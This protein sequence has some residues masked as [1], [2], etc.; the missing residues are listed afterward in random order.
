MSSFPDDTMSRTRGVPRALRR[1]LLPAAVLLVAMAT[2]APASAAI[3]SRGAA[4]VSTY[5]SDSATTIAVS[6]PAGAQPG[7]VLVASIGFGRSSAKSQPALTAP[8]GWTLVLRTNQGSVGALAVYRHVYAAGETSY[9]WTANAA[10]GGAAFVSAF[11]GV[12][13][14]NPVDTSAGRTMGKA[15]SVA[16]PSITASAAGEMLVASYY[17]YR[18]SGGGTTWTPPP[19]MSELGDASNGSSRSGSVDAALQSSAGSTG[20][21]TAKASAQQDYAIASLLALRPAPPPSTPPVID[22]VQAGAVST[23]TATVSWITDQPADSQVD[24]GQ[25]SSYGATKTNGTA[26]AIHSQNLTGL[27][28]NAVYHYRVSSRNASGQV[29]VSPDYTFQTSA[30]GAVPLI[31]DTDIFSDADDVGALASA[32]GLQVRGEAQVVAIGVNTRLSRPAVATSSWKC[33]S[34]ITAFYNSFAVPIGTA[35]PNNGTAVNSPDFVGP[36]S[37]LAPASTPTPESAVTVYRRAL[38][39]AP[40]GSVVMASVGYFGNLSALLDSPAD[41]ISLLTG[42]QL[43]AQKVNSLVAMAG[44]YP[45]NSGENNI[46][47]DPASAQDVAANW[48]TKIIWSGYEVGD[49]V[50]TGQTISSVHPTNSPVRVAYEAFAGAGNWIYSYDLTAIYHAIRPADS[51]LSEVGPG[52]NQISNTGANSFVSGSGNQYYLAL[53][54]ATS[55]DSSIEALLDTLP[56]SSAPPPDT[57][58]PAITGVSA[59]SV[60]SGE[61]TVGW[62]TDE[63]ATTQV[64]Y[65]TTTA[66]GS[67]TTP[68]TSLGTSHSQ[69]LSGLTPGTLY[70]YRVKSTDA[71]GNAAVSGDFT[72]TTTAAQASGLN[73]NFDSNT[74]DPGV[75]SLIQGGSTV[76]AAN[77]ELEITHPA[78]SW[79]KSGVV[80]AVTE[81]ATG[82]SVQVQLKRAANNGLGGSTYGETTIYLML[83][84]THYASFFVASGKLTA[85][86]NTGG[87]ESNQTPSWPTYNATNMQ[88]LRFRESAGRLYWEY[89]SGT[90]TPGPW[91]TLVSTGTPFAL[92][93]VR[94][95][96]VAG[97]NVNV[98]DTAKFDNVATY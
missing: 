75:W 68:D 19:G 5:P 24:Y 83:D 51:L 55:L 93:G 44:G 79:T 16:T 32:F 36:C 46:V 82:R 1:G 43:I 98:T 49:A 78:G 61:A 95:E 73:E 91:T 85:W 28:P 48:P 14:V 21:K 94:L 8:D 22:S 53:S 9:A 17:G 81:D 66:Y 64:E 89:A 4:A 87:G 31:I 39:A 70:H 54:S 20:Q 76:A 40:D 88:W 50:H 72:F 38:A 57:T 25:T 18:G 63:P 33:A 52:T 27:A 60:S 62:T 58:P 41:S 80:S 56:S 30:G 71:A 29:T 84:S 96:M 74:L 65:G 92:T 90:T 86:V 15:S 45:S 97:T 47:G 35:M 13:A 67:S 77:Q 3:T 6:A 10:V 26:V 12:D 2:A 11:A 69:T 7:D 42:R 23:T 37:Q 34:A 59:S